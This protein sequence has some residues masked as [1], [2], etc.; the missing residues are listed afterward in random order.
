M[1]CYVNPRGVS[2]EEFIY[3][4]GCLIDANEAAITPTHLP[5]CL[6]NNGPFTAAAVGYSQSEIETFQREDGRPK[7]WF[8][9]KRSDLY[10]VSDL[11]NYER[12]S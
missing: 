1:G 7:L 3:T 10:E 4:F 6:V 12:H 8:M 5:V 9:M 11:K 2:K